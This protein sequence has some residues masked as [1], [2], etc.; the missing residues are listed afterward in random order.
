MKAA[1]LPPEVIDEWNKLIAEKWD[2]VNATFTQDLLVDRLVARMNV[3]RERVF[4]AGWVDL[5]P[6]FRK[7]GWRV[8]FDKPAYNET[9][10]ATF[11]FTR[12]G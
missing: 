3:K 11:E 2:G 6:V 9:Y 8:H 4:D 5:E 10:P 12:K 7:A 1:G